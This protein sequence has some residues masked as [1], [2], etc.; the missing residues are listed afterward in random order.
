MQLLVTGDPD[1]GASWSFM[2]PR[3]SPTLYPVPFH[4]CLSLLS[5]ISFVEQKKVNLEFERWQG[6]GAWGWGGEG[7]VPEVCS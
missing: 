1:P 7:R 6:R 2:S 4:F 5:P 3:H